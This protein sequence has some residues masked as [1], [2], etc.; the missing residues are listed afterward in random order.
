MG[1]A[2]PDGTAVCSAVPAKGRVNVADRAYFR[3]ALKTQEMVMGDVI[4]GRYTGKPVITFAKAMRNG[5][6]HVTGVLFLSLD[7]T[8]LHGELAANGLTGKNI[9]DWP[10]F[11]RIQAAGGEDVLEDTGLDGERRLFAHATLLDTAAGRTTLWLS[12]PKAVIEA[13]LRRE[14]GLALGIALAVLAATLGLVVWAATGW[15]CARC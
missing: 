6:G 14:L 8:W 7:L 11:R 4:V 1:K 12:V 5:G 3:R 15:C 2:L 13:P 9:V 10:L